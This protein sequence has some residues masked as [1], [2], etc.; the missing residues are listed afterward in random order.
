MSNGRRNKM[1]IHR[2]FCTECGL[3]G[4]PILRPQDT[5]RELLHLKKLHCV[6]CGYNTNHVEISPNG[7]YEVSDFEKDLTIGKF[8]EIK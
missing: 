7:F 4:I 6:N 8:K 1:E 2:F 5:K 3:E